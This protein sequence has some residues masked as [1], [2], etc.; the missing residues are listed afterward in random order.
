M[1]CPKCAK[2]LSKKDKNLYVCR[3]CGLHLHENPRPTNGVIFENNK[4][5]V[6]LVRRKFPPKKGYWD[7]PGGFVDIGET[8]EDALRR[9]VKEELGIDVKKFAYLTSRYDRYLYKG[10]NYYTLG[11]VFVAKIP[12]QILKLADDVSEAKFF[13]KD[14]IPLSRLAFKS[15]KEVLRDYP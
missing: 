3:N 14:K 6:L 7:L 8:M 9:E 2:K 13:P 12:N 15:I 4:G 1:F 5:E 10:Q 11:F